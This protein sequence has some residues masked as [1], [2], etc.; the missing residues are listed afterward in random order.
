MH[1]L[2]IAYHKLR[3][4]LVQQRN[5]IHALLD[6][7]FPEFL[8]EFSL[9][10]KTAC[11]L[12]GKYFRPSHFLAMDIESEAEAIRKLSWGNCGRSY[13]AALQKHATRSIGI[14]LDKSEEQ[15]ER[16]ALDSWLAVIELLEMHM[17]IMM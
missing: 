11:Y 6:R 7:C 16:L 2:S 15:A 1:S 5:R 13:L 8:K 10:S 9:E 4:N 17:A 3:K 14:A 12:L